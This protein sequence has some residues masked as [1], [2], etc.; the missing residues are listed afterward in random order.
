[1]VIGCGHRREHPSQH[2]CTTTKKKVQENNVREKKYVKKKHG[3]KSKG[4][5]QVTS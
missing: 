3:E 4:K 2:L 1:M 5:S